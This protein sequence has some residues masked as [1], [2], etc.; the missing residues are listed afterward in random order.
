VGI[1]PQNIWPITISSGGN[2]GSTFDL[3]LVT[4]VVLGITRPDG[5]SVSVSPILQTPQT[6]T[7]LLVWYWWTGTEV[8]VVGIYNVSVELVYPG[9]STFCYAIG[10]FGM[11]PE[12][13]QPS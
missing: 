4:S 8:T 1:G 11:E 3:T 2:T 10:F 6:S 12:F 13:L 5:T 7:S 9:G